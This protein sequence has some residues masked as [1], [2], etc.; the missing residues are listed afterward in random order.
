MLAEKGSF[1]VGMPSCKGC[2]LS[3]LRLAYFVMLLV[4]LYETVMLG[5]MGGSFHFERR[6]APEKIL[7]FAG[8]RK[9]G[10]GAVIRGH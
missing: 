4:M 10:A 9:H 3:C 2:D 7:Q 8:K 1:C 6:S 5:W